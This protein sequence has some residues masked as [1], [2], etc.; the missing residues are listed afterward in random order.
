[1]ENTKQKV[2]DFLGELAE[3]YLDRP[4][5]DAV[6]ADW[7]KKAR[8][9]LEELVA[10]GEIS[11]FSVVAHGIGPGLAAIGVRQIEVQVESLS[12]KYMAQI[13][14]IVVPGQAA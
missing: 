14:K 8:K 6:V 3:G 4:A 11:G 5:D 13:G 7:S 2:S 10:S 9:F 1:M 12:V